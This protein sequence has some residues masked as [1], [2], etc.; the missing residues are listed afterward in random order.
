[1]NGNAAIFVGN[2]NP[3]AMTQTKLAKSSLDASWSSF[4]T[5]LEYKCAHAGVVF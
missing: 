4:K 5:M 1:V 3:K 2:V